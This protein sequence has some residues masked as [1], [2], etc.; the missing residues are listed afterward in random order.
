M[1]WGVAVGGGEKAV[2]TVEEEK[3]GVKGVEVKGEAT[4]AEGKVEAKVE[5]GKVEAKVEAD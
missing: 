4:V 1:G 2:E 3:E 5:A